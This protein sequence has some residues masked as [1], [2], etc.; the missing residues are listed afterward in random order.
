MEKQVRHVVVFKFKP[1]TTQ[2]QLATLADRFRD[3]KNQIPGIVAFE[4]GTNNS[5]EGLD[6]GFTHVFLLTF[7]D[8]NARDAY[9]PHP[10]H[11]AFVE[12]MGSTN[13]VEGAFVV[14]Y[15]PRS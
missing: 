11:L 2:E 3:L 6:Q 12:W 1:E 8:V 15:V 7:A 4:S 10:A 9:L 14:D 5:T 13:A